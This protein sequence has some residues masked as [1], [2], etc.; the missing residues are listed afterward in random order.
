MSDGSDLLVIVPTRGRRANCERLI[1]SFAATASPG[2]DLLFVTDPD[3]R[4]TYAGMNWGPAAE[5]ALEPRDYLVGKLNKTAVAMADV[6]DVI[7]WFG[8]DCVFRPPAEDGTPPWDQ[9]ML[10]MLAEMGGTGWVYADDKRR[11]DVPEHWMCS[12]DIIRE[13][14]WYACP[15]MSHYL[16]DNVVAEL[17]KRSGLIRYCPQAVVEHMH[18]S[19]APGTERDEVYQSTEEMF[20]AADH[21]AFLG[22]RA[23]EMPYQ[24]ARLRRAFSADV[25]W[26]LS[27][28]A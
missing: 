8:D 23:D 3:D 4:D 25:S 11:N 7:A 28:V 22:W 10:G 9:A 16:I 21:Q 1:E 18:Y 15:R 19:V 5:A 12:S 20:G 27:R 14:G 26:V 2:T 17:G 24:V 13:L 6:Y